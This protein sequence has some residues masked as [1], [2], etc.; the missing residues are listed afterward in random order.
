MKAGLIGLLLAMTLVG[1][2]AQEAGSSDEVNAEWLA[3]VCAQGGQTNLTISQQ[4]AW[5]A[6]CVQRYGRLVKPPP[7]PAGST[8]VAYVPPPPPAAT[9][10]TNALATLGVETN[11]AS[12]T[13][14][15]VEMRITGGSANMTVMRSGKSST[16]DM[17]QGRMRR[18]DAKPGEK[19]TLSAYAWNSR[20]LTLS[21]RCNGKE[22]K[23]SSDTGGNV[24]ITL[25][26]EVP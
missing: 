18:L 21:V 22:W 26:I 17:P 5:V 10:R 15:V 3:S 4:R 1:A 23:K 2:R 11:S 25:E 14:R 24:T 20:A 7:A 16:I 12:A 9:P 19:L 6:S 8:P 13:E